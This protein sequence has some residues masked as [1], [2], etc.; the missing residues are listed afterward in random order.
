MAFQS[1]DTGYK[2]E[3]SLGALYQG[4]N[5][6]NA[7]ASTEEEL[8]RQ[9]LA[10][11]REQQ[12]QPIDIAQKMQDL[13]AGQYKTSPEYQEGMRNT[14]FGQGKSNL[15]AGQKAEMLL[16]FVQAA[17][18]AKLGKEESSDQLLGNINRNLLTQF[19]QSK[20]DNERISANQRALALADSMSRVDPKIIANER[21]L[22]MK[23]DNALDLQDMKGT[24]AEKLA[25][26]KA[27]AVQG[28]KTAQQAI[29]RVLTEQKAQGLITEE[30]YA[31][32]L[33][34]LQN[35]INSAK[36]QPGNTLNPETN[37]LERKEGQP[38]YTPPKTT[39]GAAAVPVGTTK[40][41]G[42][43]TYVKTDKGWMVQ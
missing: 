20:P 34:D 12:V 43:K 14:I 29:V 40:Q 26:L 15:S 30:Q 8:I 31:Q 17:E 13:D 18:K 25:V 9:F 24:V 38:Q 2:P 5:A 19:D 3:F 1:I 33:A 28:D 35:S 27:K 36:V 23:L 10:N 7:D 22:G 32:S 41:V 4:Q 21:M 39:Q 42:G 11:Q 37:T 16:P 6:A